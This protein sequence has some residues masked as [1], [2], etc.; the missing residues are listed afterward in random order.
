ME[1]R[2]SACYWIRRNF[3]ASGFLLVIL[4]GLVDTACQRSGSSY[5]SATGRSYAKKSGSR[6]T[7]SATHWSNRAPSRKSARTASSRSAAE[8]ASGSGT[9]ASKTG[10]ERRTPTR[11]GST[12]SESSGRRSATASAQQVIRAARSYTGTRYR[13]GGT[14]RKGMD[15]SGLL[16]T[17]FQ[18]VDITLPR[19]SAEQARYGEEV[20]LSRVEPGDL[21]FFSERKGGSKVSH[22]GMVTEVNGDDVRF[23]HASTSRGVIEDNLYSDYFQKIFVK[24]VRPF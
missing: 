6:T 3:A 23:I 14:T 20:R 24:A 17:S 5:W 13:Y 7:K 4:L 21:V 10:N 18:A 1:P 22:V 16:C 15:C 8:A 2:H 9:G 19:T 12:V 11:A